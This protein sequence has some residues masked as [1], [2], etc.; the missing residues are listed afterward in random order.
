LDKRAQVRTKREAAAQARRLATAFSQDDDRKRLLDF[1]ADLDRQA[2]ELERQ[3]AAT[4]S[5]TQVQM[6]QQQ[7]EQGRPVAEKNDKKE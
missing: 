6:Q 7:A 4:S 5:Q 2:D 1:A 3:V